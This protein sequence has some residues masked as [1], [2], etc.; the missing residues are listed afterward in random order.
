MKLNAFNEIMTSE[1][2]VDSN[3]SEHKRN[4]NKQNRK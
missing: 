3:S 2:L 4:L 1:T